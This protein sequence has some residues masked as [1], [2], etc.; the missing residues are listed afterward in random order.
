[1]ALG[2]WFGFASFRF[3]GTP[4]QNSLKDL[5]MS[6]AFL[7]L[8]P[9]D[10]WE[11]WNRVIQRPVTLGDNTGLQWVFR[12]WHCDVYAPPV[13]EI[14]LGHLHNPPTKMTALLMYCYSAPI[15]GMRKTIMLRGFP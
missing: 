11:W 3:A 6:I 5:W 2:N 1:M 13:P 15:G 9:F 4:I 14:P 10:V 12:G 7:K 8:K